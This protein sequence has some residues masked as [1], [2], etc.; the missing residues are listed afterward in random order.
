MDASAPQLLKPL[1]EAIVHEVRDAVSKKTILP[2]QRLWIEWKLS[3]FEYT[4]DGPS[5]GM[6]NGNQISKPDWFGAPRIL[7]PRI[8]TLAIY[9]TTLEALKKEYPNQASPMADY[10]GKFTL[11]AIGIVLPDADNVKVTE[12]ENLC[13][14]FLNDLAGGPITHRAKVN[15]GGVVLK[16]LSIQ[17]AVGIRLR[18][19]TREDIE[20]ASPAAQFD[21]WQNPMAKIPQAIAEIEYVGARDQ[22]VD[23]QREV[24]HFISVLRLFGVGSVAY[25]SYEMESDS[26]LSLWRAR[27]T[28]SSGIVVTARERYVIGREDEDRLKAFW[29]VVAQAIP[30]DIYDFEKQVSP[31]TLAYD[32]YSDAVLHN[33]IVER[34]IANAVMGLEALLL[35]EIQELSYRLGMRIAKALS[36][37]GKRPLEVRQRIHDAYRIRSLFAHGGHLSYKEKAKFERKYGDMKN[38]MLPL[39][40]YLRSLIVLMISIHRDKEQVI[41]MLDDALID[42][43]KHD[44]LKNMV[45]PLTSL[46][47]GGS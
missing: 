1:V 42:P 8:T 2:E 32:R 22:T 33:G 15:L 30:K 26:I 28:L 24:E 29:R 5:I 3:S 14:S 11:I 23:L 36:L 47:S 46:I 43:D 41:D 19:P 34:R 21:H 20:I 17:I 6:A 27:S 9:E 31:I 39:F 10:L 38:F 37:I 13:T 18:Q 4:D 40:D 12:L 25:T 16:S 45:T 44:N 7:Q 35:D